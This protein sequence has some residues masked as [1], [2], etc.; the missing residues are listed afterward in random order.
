MYLCIRD[1]V[2]TIV[3]HQNLVAQADNFLQAIEPYTSDLVV[4]CEYMFAWYWVADL[5]AEHSIPFVLGHALY[6]KAI[7]GGKSKNDKLDADKL[8]AL[9]RGG[10]FPVAYVYPK[11]LRETR[12]LLRRRSFFVRQRALLFAHVQNTNSQYNLPVFG[13]KLG[14]RRQIARS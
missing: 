12:D 13:K 6:L 3:F 10:N 11:G 4:G 5:C 14:S 9:L 7:H 2:G 1:Q 8:S